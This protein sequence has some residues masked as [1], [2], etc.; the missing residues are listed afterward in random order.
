MQQNFLTEKE[1]D[2]LSFAE[3]YLWQI[4][5]YLHVLTG[6]NENKLLFDYQREIAQLM[7]YETQPDD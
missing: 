1:F 5:H 4:R 2:E 3:G 7:G 6:R